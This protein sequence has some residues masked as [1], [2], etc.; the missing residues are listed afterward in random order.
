MSSLAD[1]KATVIASQT[2]DLALVE[3]E[4][5]Y[6]KLSTE[7][8][9]EIQ[10]GQ[11]FLTEAKVMLD[12]CEQKMPQYH[13]YWSGE[14]KEWI[15]VRERFADFA[16][17]LTKALETKPSSL[18]DYAATYQALVELHKSANYF[19]IVTPQNFYERIDRKQHVRSR[20]I[21]SEH[22][23]QDLRG[24]SNDIMSKLLRPGRETL[25]AARELLDL[26][27]K[28][29]P[30]FNVIWDTMER[31]YTLYAS[32]FIASEKL[33]RRDAANLLGVYS[34]MESAGLTPD[35]SFFEQEIQPSLVKYSEW[36]IDAPKH[37]YEELR[38]QHQVCEMQVRDPKLFE[39]AT[40][41]VMRSGCTEKDAGFVPKVMAVIEKI[42]KEREPSPEHQEEIR[43]K[44]LALIQKKLSDFE[45][46]LHEAHHILEQ[47]RRESEGKA[48]FLI[49]VIVYEREFSEGNTFLQRFQKIY[50]NECTTLDGVNKANEILDDFI[51][52]SK[53]QD[54]YT[55]VIAL[56]REIDSVQTMRQAPT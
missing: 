43:K 18:K 21:P 12:Q 23:I 50:Q 44:Q 22:K 30:A 41:I 5:K 45:K 31:T 53:V 26:C 4:A 29:T 33:F 8:V 47:C 51:A 14:Q 36:L 17:Y 20:N 49:K 10:A 11:K 40:A 15:W 9:S 38:M 48:Q 16:G 13:E 19:V 24:N 39:K 1:L 7:I 52:Y 32:N 55:N 54:F 37:F 34:S 56:Q 6:K 27:K 42:N 35:W 28:R 3:Y 2:S 25:R 46:K